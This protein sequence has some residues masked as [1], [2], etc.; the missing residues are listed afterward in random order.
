MDLPMGLR[1]GTVGRFFL[2]CGVPD[3]IVLS[4]PM[5]LLTGIF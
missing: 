2:K 4:M 3:A 5:S 1:R